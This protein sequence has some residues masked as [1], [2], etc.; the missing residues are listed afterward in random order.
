[1][2]QRPELEWRKSSRCDSGACL[3]VAVI[4]NGILV[5]DSKNSAG[6]VLRFGRSEW[7][8]FIEGIRQGDLR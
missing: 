4:D 6:P 7:N 8:A 1:L 3:E 2:D 5:R